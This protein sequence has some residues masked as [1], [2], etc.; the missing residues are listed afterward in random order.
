MFAL[1]EEEIKKKIRNRD[2]TICI[3]GMGKIGLP[4][5]C[6]FAD[7]GFNVIGVDVSPKV[8]DNVNS[9]TT[10]FFEPE[11]D[12]KLIRTTKNKKLSATLDGEDAVKRSDFISPDDYVRD[13]NGRVIG[14]KSFKRLL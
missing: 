11:L 4:M 7:A 5:A 14:I 1:D 2:L 12:E 6:A 10:W 3:F 8:V 9:G 13:K